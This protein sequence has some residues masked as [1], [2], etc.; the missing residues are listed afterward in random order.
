MK[1]VLLALLATCCV[2]AV[3]AGVSLGITENAQVSAATQSDPFTLSVSA[4]NAA[5][6]E[7]NPYYI[8]RVLFD[9]QLIPMDAYE[10]EKDLQ[11]GD[12]GIG[13]KVFL[14]GYSVN[15]INANS[16]LGEDVVRLYW[17]ANDI[18]GGRGMFRMDIL[19]RDF[20]HPAHPHLA[21]EFLVELAEGITTP[22]NGELPQMAITP[23]PDNN[24]IIP[25]YIALGTQRGEASG[26]TTVKSISPTQVPDG[27]NYAFN[28]YFNENCAERTT[29]NQWNNLYI[30]DKV[31]IN[32]KTI[33]EIKAESVNSQGR[34]FADAIDL[35]WFNDAKDPNGRLSIYIKRDIINEW[36]F[37][38]D[39]TD[40]LEFLAGFRT[41]TNLELKE[42]VK[43]R[44][45]TR[46]GVWQEVTDEENNGYI[47]QGKQVGEYI[48]AEVA[49]P[50]G[51]VLPSSVSAEHFLWNGRALTDTQVSVV[52]HGGTRSLSLLIPKT[53][54]SADETDTLTIK[55]TLALESGSLAADVALPLQ[56]APTSDV[57]MAVFDF[58]ADETCEIPVQAYGKT[59]QVLYGENVLTAEQYTW[60]GTTFSFAPNYLKT[61]SLGIQSF[62]IKTA[63]G[64]LVI[65]VKLE[66]SQAEMLGETAYTYYDRSGKDLQVYFNANNAGDI[67]SIT[68]DDTALHGRYFQTNGLGILIDGDYL[69]TLSQ[70]TYEVV[71]QTETNAVDFTL[72]VAD[73]R[74][75][76][77]AM[78]S[79]VFAVQVDTKG[80]DILGVKLDGKELTMKEYT[81]E[82]GVL[83]L[84]N[85]PTAAGKYALEITTA[86]GS[87]EREIIITTQSSGC[88]SSLTVLGVL[89]VLA[90]CGGLAVLKKKKD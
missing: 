40:T 76:V 47:F 21:G 34:H 15:Q 29:V 69:S 10:T 65:P 89:P 42:S 37:K 5:A 66:N 38:F 77:T 85:A 50:F 30:Y 28:V 58:Y 46:F 81:F 56:L 12:S 36:G 3:S 79:M 75:K 19:K 16:S 73:G 48:R 74:P 7:L 4:V 87:V 45:I 57:N 63:N 84:A 35:H 59:V 55:S 44:Y 25:D 23:Y 52:T 82:D 9:E 88:G 71:I 6:D 13:D 18:S 80:V 43:Y 70:G 11:Q 22:T 60:D 90:V 31:R 62:E 64:S 86:Y 14:N 67:V 51:T 53:A 1:K 24:D 20:G 27:E 72:T 33:T 54:L 78:E 26:E 61:L 41:A 8:V 68:L 17:E 2:G 83:T 32:G 39:D 49:F